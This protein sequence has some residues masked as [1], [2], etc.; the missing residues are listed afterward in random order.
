MTLISA[1]IPAILASSLPDFQSIL[2]APLLIGLIIVHGA[3]NVL[4]D[5]YDTKH[6]VDTADAPTAQY[7]RHP[8]ISGDISPRALKRYALI[9]YLA[10]ILLALLLTYHRGLPVL[11]F[12]LLGLLVSIFYTADPVSYKHLALGEVAA[13]LMWGPVMMGA[14]FYVLAGSWTGAKQVLLLSIPQGLW[15]GLVLFANNL[16]DISFDGG[17]GISTLGTRFGRAKSRGIFVAALLVIYIATVA[18]VLWGV[19]PL[20]SLLTLLS[21]P[22][23]LSLALRLTRGD[24]VPADADPRTA[25]VGMVFGLLL[26]FSL[27]IERFFA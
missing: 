20:W 15:V 12:V 17:K 25:Q 5:Y 9:L 19:L 3:T 16:K 22:L 13:F 26:L 2:I 6:G 18:E 24:E 7:R 21:M 8:L 23:A 4:N 11:G 10:A 14:S 27:G 1:L